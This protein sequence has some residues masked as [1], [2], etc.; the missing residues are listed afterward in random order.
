MSGTSL[1]AGNQWQKREKVKNTFVDK[2]SSVICSFKTIEIT[3]KIFQLPQV[4]L[5]LI[6]WSSSLRTLASPDRLRIP[7]VSIGLIAGCQTLDVT[8]W[9]CSCPLCLETLGWAAA[10]PRRCGFTLT[11]RCPSSRSR[12][13]L[14]MEP[15]LT[16]QTACSVHVNTGRLVLHAPWYSQQH[17]P[18]DE[19]AAP[20]VLHAGPHV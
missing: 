15:C 3:M 12:P 9:P 10:G 4:R 2:V 14:L 20:N 11:T 1:H 6:R 13:E 19:D 16:R 18:V 5:L 7:T 8:L 17:H